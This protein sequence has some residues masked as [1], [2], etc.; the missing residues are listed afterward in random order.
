MTFVCS[1]SFEKGITR[2]DVIVKGAAELVNPIFQIISASTAMQCSSM[3]W[4]FSKST[5][6][7]TVK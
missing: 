3:H 4:N 5:A 7:T 6:T 2:E 1:D